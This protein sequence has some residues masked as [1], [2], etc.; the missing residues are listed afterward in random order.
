[1]LFRLNISWKILKSCSTIMQ[2]LMMFPFI[3]F[4]IN[5]RNEVKYTTSDNITITWIN[6]FYMWEL[7]VY[8]IYVGIIHR[9]AQARGV[10]KDQPLPAC[11]RHRRQWICPHREVHQS[12][13]SYLSNIY[14]NK[15]QTIFYI[16]TAR[17]TYI[18]D[19]D[20]VSITPKMSVLGSINQKLNKRTIKHKLHVWYLIIWSINW[21]GGI[22]I[23]DCDFYC[24]FSVAN[25]ITVIL[26]LC[27]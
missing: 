26:Y 2:S 14:Q 12:I 23:R 17:K 8:V 25:I 24:S 20:I 4:Y 11:T 10:P 6:S 9:R 3:E 5:K 1:M 22:K 21:G 7:E 13:S 18:I 27:N 15:T 16:G 19:I